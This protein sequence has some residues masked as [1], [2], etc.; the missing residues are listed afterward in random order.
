MAKKKEELTEEDKTERN[1]VI[2]PALLGVPLTKIRE[3]YFK[4]KVPAMLDEMLAS[5]ALTDENAHELMTYLEGIKSEKENVVQLVVDTFGG[6]ILNI[7]DAPPTVKELMEGIAWTQDEEERAMKVV[8][9]IE[10]ELNN[11]RQNVAS[12]TNIPQS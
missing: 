9:Y 6:K 3:A 5:G 8:A 11:L 1:L 12:K 7:E 2:A 10:S 4:N